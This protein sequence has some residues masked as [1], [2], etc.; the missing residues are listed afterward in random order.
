MVGGDNILTAYHTADGSLLGIGKDAP[1]LSPARVSRCPIRILGKL[2]IPPEKP[3]NGNTVKGQSSV[4]VGSHISKIL[5]N[6]KQLFERI[7]GP[8]AVMSLADGSFSFRIALVM[9]T[10]VR[11]N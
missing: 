6:R 4:I 3:R 7:R 11:M 10:R 8:P 9:A 2:L 1:M 5:E